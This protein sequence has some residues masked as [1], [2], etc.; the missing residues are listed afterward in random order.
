MISYFRS[1]VAHAVE[2]H[3]ACILPLKIT[4]VTLRPG[5]QCDWHQTIFSPVIPF[6]HNFASLSTG[7]VVSPK[8]TTLGA[9]SV[10]PSTVL[11]TNNVAGACWSFRGHAGSLGVVLDAPNVTPSQIVMV[12]WPSNST[13][14]LSCAPRK[15][16]AWGL[17]DGD[18]NM[19]IYSRSLT[20]TFATPP[21]PISKEGV[22][23]S[24]GEISFDI[25]ARSLRQA[26]TLNSEML[27]WGI[28][29]GVIVFEIHNNWGGDSTELCS[30]R[31][32]GRTFTGR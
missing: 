29:Y 4:Q 28:D 17:V 27:S 15:V 11:M 14:S 1:N 26:F 13:D 6:G 31:I 10:P 16:T 9:A 8:L 24:I 21:S 7:A 23:L 25:T 5:L 3:L 30:V 32:Y 12:H 22:F 18:Q 20:R 19:K 2:Q